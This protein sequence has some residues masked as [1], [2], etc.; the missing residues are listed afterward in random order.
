[1]VLIDI[2]GLRSKRGISSYIHSIVSGLVDK[3]VECDR[4]IFLLAPKSVARDLSVNT[5]PENVKIISKPYINQIIWEI[6]LVPIYAKILGA[7]LIH[8]TGNT[9]GVLIPKLFNIP[10]VVTIHDVSFLKQSEI[11]PRPELLR[12]KIGYLYRNYNT[13]KVARSA[14]RIITVS[15]FAKRDILS[16]ISCDQDKVL[17]VHNALRDEFFA[18]EKSAEREKVILLVTGDGGQKNLDPTLK[19]LTKNKDKLPDWLVLVVGI[20]GRKSTDFIQYAGKVNPVELVRYYDMATLFLMPSLY[21]SFSIPVIEALSRK[22]FVVASNRGAVSEVLGEYGLKYDPTSCLD[23]LEKI[24]CGIANKDTDNKSAAKRYA[25][26]FS[27]ENLVKKT[28]SVY[29]EALS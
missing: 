6:F 22:A 8:Y 2:G 17:V 24:E 4:E 9:G 25:K 27:S 23:L 29:Q 16:E 18:K 15:E 20:D 3:G 26:S 14:K 21:E 10:F 5:I 11:V 12:Q 19:C 1:M 13:P 28:L 7:S